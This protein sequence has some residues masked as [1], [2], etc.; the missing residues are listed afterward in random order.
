MAD[1]ISLRDVNLEDI[2]QITAIYNL[3]VAG[4]I[5]SLQETESTVAELQSKC[6][7]IQARGL[8]FLV[9]VDEATDDICGY[10]YAN[11]CAERT[12]YRFSVESSIYLHPDRR[13]NGLG[14]RL[15]AAL[16]NQIKAC[17]RKR[18]LVKISILP[19]QSQS[20]VASCRLHMSYGF[21]EAGR[22]LKVGFKFDRWIDVIILELDL[23][24]ASL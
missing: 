9:A 17:G 6:M 13:G 15:L 24:E 18:V 21:Q 11:D 8:P 20:E 4:T 7:S 10:A 12:G 5:A 2:E 14:K 19:D 23:D 16:L 22:L 3:Y 1:N